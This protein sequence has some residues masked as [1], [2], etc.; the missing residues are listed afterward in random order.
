MDATTAN[1]YG[2]RAKGNQQAA[3]ADF[4]RTAP[5]WKGAVA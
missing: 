3:C 5:T 1:D 4:G 2:E